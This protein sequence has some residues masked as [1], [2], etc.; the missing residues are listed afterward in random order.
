MYLMPIQCWNMAG[1]CLYPRA[2][3]NILLC[4][5]GVEK[6]I[7][8]YEDKKCSAIEKKCTYTS[9]FWSEMGLRHLK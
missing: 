1:T 6:R 9:G 2:K 7:Y 8:I 5:N 4:N 3:P